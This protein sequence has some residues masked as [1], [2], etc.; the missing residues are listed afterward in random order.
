M[1]S[2][3]EERAF[4]LVEV[5]CYLALLLA[6]PLLRAL[7][8]AQWPYFTP[9][10]FTLLSAVGIVYMLRFFIYANPEQILDRQLAT[11]ISLS[12]DK[13]LA[14]KVGFAMCVPMLFFGC[15]GLISPPAMEK[16]IWFLSPMRFIMQ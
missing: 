4:R 7:R 5:T 14:L 11:S 15:L 8:G 10:L 1:I 13:K 12:S 3:N 6:T 9:L 2:R 16:L